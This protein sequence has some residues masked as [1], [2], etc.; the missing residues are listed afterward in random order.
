MTGI[1]IL[2]VGRWGVHLVRN[3]LNHPDA[4]V[5]AIVDPRQDRLE[6]LWGQFEL[7][8]D[9]VLATSWN[10]IRQ[11]SDRIEA[12]AVATPASTHYS[13]ISDALDLGY[14]VLSEKPLTLNPEESLEL[15]QLAE[16]QQRQLFIDHTYLFHPAVE[17]GANVIRNA[18]LGELRYGYAA[19]THLGP[20]RPDVDALWDLAIHDIAIF[21]TWLGE[22][23]DRVAATGNI[24]LQSATDKLDRTLFPNGLSDVVWAK[25]IYPSGFQ[26]TIHLCWFNPDKQRRLS[27]VGARGTLIF[28]EMSSVAPLVIQRGRLELRDG[29]WIP[30]DQSRDVLELEPAEPLKQM[31]DRFL[32]CIGESRPCDISSGWVGAK[33]VKILSALTES[34]NQGGLEVRV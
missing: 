3:F 5:V 20:V 8:P 17:R 31:C 21:N 9:V 25:L 27:V 6:A 28:D 23:P 4:K 22:F 2:G 26:A 34:L 10:Q 18:E 11:M 29:Y 7:S 33:L 24:W 32:T 19:R 13:L 1:A 15:C 14:H 12:V 16:K 30:T